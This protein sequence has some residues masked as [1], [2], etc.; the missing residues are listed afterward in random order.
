MERAQMEINPPRDRYN[1]VFL[2]LILHGIGTL[3]PW[4]M[5]I[6]AQSY[7]E[8]FK[9]NG[10]SYRNMFVLAIGLSSQIPNVV[11]NWMNIFVQMGYVCLAF[12]R[13]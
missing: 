4:N 3:I 11:F 13:N 7:F 6:N 1:L 10:T 8:D 9:L 12:I 2:I 5:F